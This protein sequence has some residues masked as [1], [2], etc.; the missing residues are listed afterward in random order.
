MERLL[1]ENLPFVWSD[2]S[3][4]SFQRK[5]RI[6]M[7]PLFLTHF[8][9]DEPLFLALDA[10]SVGVGAVL[11]HRIADVSKSLTPAER[12]YSQIER[13]ALSIVFR[14]KKFYQY[15]WERKFTLLTDYQPLTIIF[16]SKKAVPLLAANQLK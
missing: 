4:E 11:F 2:R 14:I 6:L 7:S 1:Q 5:K 9:P 8:Q 13:E 12:N 15:L 10:S 16:G 3:Q